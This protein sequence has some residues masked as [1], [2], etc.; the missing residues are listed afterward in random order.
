M[1]FRHGL[2]SP[3][4]SARQGLNALEPIWRILDTANERR[5]R[6]ARDA[7]HQKQM[8][9]Q[10]NEILEQLQ[11]G[12]PILIYVLFLLST[13]IGIGIAGKLTP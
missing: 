1:T 13:I 3:L 6:R 10:M 9:T 4:R 12:N 5:E 7:S 8:E 11:N 2:S